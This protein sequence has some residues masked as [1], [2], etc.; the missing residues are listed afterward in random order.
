[1]LQYTVLDRIKKP[2]VIYK[3]IFTNSVCLEPRRG[4]CEKKAFVISLPQSGSHMIQQIFSNIGMQHI[5]VQHDRHNIGD[6]RFMTDQERIDFSRRD[7]S[8][9]FSLAETHKWIMNGQFAHNHLKYDDNAYILLRDSDL[10]MYLLKRDLRNCLV[11]HARSKQQGNIYCSNEQSK[12]MDM[13]VTSSYHHEIIETIKLQ[14]P[15]FENNTFDVLSFEDLSGQNGKD[16]Q[17]QNIMKL[18]EDV[19][20]PH[21]QMDDI[22]KKSIN[23]KTFSYS[24]DN[25]NWISYWSEKIERWYQDSGLKQMNETLGYH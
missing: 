2:F 18:L 3:D 8:Y 14:L 10:M 1:M 16:Q 13:Y 24:G 22:I 11:S 23:V 25:S 12:L 15:W 7:D 20:L 17:Y 4:Y 9:S 5:R 19:E 6:Y 21:L